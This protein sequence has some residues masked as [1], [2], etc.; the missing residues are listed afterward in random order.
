MRLADLCNGS[1]P[2]SDSVCEGSN[3]SPA[4]KTGYRLVPSFLYQTLFADEKD[5]EA[6]EIH[7][8]LRQ[9]LRERGW[10]EY[11]PSRK[12]GLAQ[13]TI[14]NLFRRNTR[15]SLATLAAICSGF[16]ITVSQFFADADMV[17]LTPDLKELFDCWVCFI[18]SQ[19]AAALQLRKAMR[20]DNDS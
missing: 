1:T 16:G 3:P 20:C 18:P 4:A 9:L 2:D 10:P 12:C 8:R 13:S 14:G 15:P 17:E 11:K 6:M 19:K 7:A 5:G